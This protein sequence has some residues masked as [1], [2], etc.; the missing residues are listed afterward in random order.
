GDPVN[1]KDPT[2]H[3]KF[4]NMTPVRRYEKVPIGV[5]LRY[6]P[7]GLDLTKHAANSAVPVITSPAAASTPAI[8]A[9]ASPSATANSTLAKASV[10][11]GNVSISSHGGAGSSS[12]FRGVQTDVGAPLDRTGELEALRI[13]YLTAARKVTAFKIQNRGKVSSGLT[14]LRIDH[15]EKEIAYRSLNEKSGSFFNFRSESN[16]KYKNRK[17]LAKA[18]RDLDRLRSPT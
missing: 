13:S 18:K 7:S 2:G 6:V 15:L 4:W 16:A 14:T 17:F 1:S 3:A 5:D 8:P 10:S 9:I 11:G 12:A